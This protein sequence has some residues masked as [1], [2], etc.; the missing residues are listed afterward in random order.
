MPF[1]QPHSSL[2]VPDLMQPSLGDLMSMVQIRHIKLW[3]AGNA[4]NWGLLNHEV[5]QISDVLGKSAV[6]YGNI[7]LNL[8]GTIRDPIKRIS[9]AARYRRVPVGLCRP[10]DGMQFL[11][12]GG[13]SWIYL[14]PVADVI[15]LHPSGAAPAVTARKIGA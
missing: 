10:D 11:S 8:V 9:A 1:A 12:C 13:R 2:S 6:L 4:Q 5:R 14:D 3:F 15:P 7:P